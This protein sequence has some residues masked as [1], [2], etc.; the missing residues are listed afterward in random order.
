MRVATGI[1][2]MNLDAP[3]PTRAMLAWTLGA[4]FVLNTMNFVDRLLLGVV[5]ELIKTDLA[6]TDFQLGLLGGPAFAFLYILAALPFARW[7]DRYSRVNIISIAFAMW[8]AMTSFCGIASSFF[9]LLIGRAGVS[10]GEAGCTPASHS[11]ISD[12]FPPERRMSAISVYATGG[13]VGAL[14]AAIGGGQLA[15]HF[16]WRATFLICGA[17]GVL[18]AMVF[19]ATVREPVRVHAAAE[20]PKFGTAIRVLLGKRSYRRIAAAG[21]LAAL[22][23][24]STQQYM[25]SFLMRSHGMSLATAATTMGIV[26]GGI[27]IVA[28]LLAGPVM[29]RARPRFPRIRTWLPAAGLAWSGILYVLAYR[30]PGAPLAVAL[31]VTASLGQHFYMPA[32]YTLAQDVAPAR[33]R[34]TSS[35]LIIATVSIVGYGLGPPALG[36]ASDVLSNVAMHAHGTTPAACAEISTGLCAAARSDGLRLSMSLGSL[37]FVAAAIVFALSGR[38]LERDLHA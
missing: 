11:L 20:A 24:F 13:P 25:V 12:Y 3:I 37:G 38:T 9:Y 34:A 18:A 7:A 8:S 26:I 30:V 32:M 4:L 17:F 19:R 2:G 29:D 28:T 31:L 22:A 36:L 5:Q 23:S 15:R 35:A 27:G 16:G 33:M 21:A 1:E 14:I 6:L 10:I